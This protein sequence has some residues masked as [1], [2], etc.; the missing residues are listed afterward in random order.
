M[1]LR[2]CI[3][4]DNK[5]VGWSHYCPGCGNDHLIWVEQPNKEGARWTF[6]G[7]EAVPTFNPSIRCY[8]WSKWDTEKQ[9]PAEGAVQITTCHYH[10]HAG[11]LKYCADSKHELAGK[12]V[13]LPDYD[14]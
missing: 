2:R 13:P 8:Y 12:N 4:K 7:N 3:D 5:P 1:K 6:D 9:Q 11:V 14:P 10:L